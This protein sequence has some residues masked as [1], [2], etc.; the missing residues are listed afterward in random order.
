MT[1]DVEPL[2]HDLQACEALEHF[3]VAGAGMDGAARVRQKL[4]LEV[5][6]CERGDRHQLAQPQ[7]ERGPAQDAP[8]GRVDREPGE[9]G[10]EIV[11][12]VVHLATL[13][14]V[15]RAEHPATDLGRGR[16][17]RFGSSLVGQH[18]GDRCERGQCPREAGEQNALQADFAHRQRVAGRAL[19]DR[20]EQLEIGA[21][22]RG[23]ADD[24]EPVASVESRTAERVHESSFGRHAG[25][26]LRWASVLALVFLASCKPEK[27]RADPERIH[28][29]RDPI[30]VHGVGQVT[31]ADFR[32]F[33]ARRLADKWLL[34]LALDRALAAE[35]AA[36]ETAPPTRAVIARVH[37]W[38]GDG[39]LHEWLPAQNGDW[40]SGKAAWD[41]AWCLGRIWVGANGATEPEKP[42][43]LVPLFEQQLAK[44]K[45]TLVAAGTNSDDLAVCEGHAVG[46][47]EVYPDLLALMTK[48][49]RRELVEAAIH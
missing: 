47:F 16:S 3:V 10:V 39:L 12:P 41:L 44:H 22:D 7:L 8:V 29:E 31:R 34:F 21:D 49:Q 14:A 15:D 19:C 11:H 2:K 27:P 23:Q 13:R 35:L 4:R 1:A 40:K 25:S 24:R 32:R 37:G 45:P 28:F 9:D 26:I 46:V 30:V 42:D 33:V 5:E 38:I 17:V 18:V 43:D 6:D 20:V 48:D 36:S